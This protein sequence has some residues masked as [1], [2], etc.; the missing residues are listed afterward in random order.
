MH[1]K[2][3]SQE[4]RR[5]DMRE[6][7]KVNDKKILRAVLAE[8]HIKTGFERAELDHYVSDYR[9]LLVDSTIQNKINALENVLSVTNKNVSNLKGYFEKSLGVTFERANQIKQSFEQSKKAHGL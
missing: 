8:P 2:S 6:A 3:V 1:F 9:N 4:E 5:K 7:M